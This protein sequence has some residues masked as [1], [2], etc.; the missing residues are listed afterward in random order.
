VCV[1]GR[2]LSLSVVIRAALWQLYT[3]STHML[4]HRRDDDELG[5]VHDTDS[6]FNQLQCFIVAC[7]TVGGSR[8]GFPYH[9][10]YIKI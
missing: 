2:D 9:Q 5:A 10:F 3:K 7:I 1:A 8:N 4:S 6:E